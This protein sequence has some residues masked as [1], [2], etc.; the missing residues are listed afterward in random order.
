MG[1]ADPREWPWPWWLADLF[2][3]DVTTLF[4][5]YVKSALFRGV[6][7]VPDADKA[8]SGRD[9]A[10]VI[11]ILRVIYSADRIDEAFIDAGLARRDIVELGVA[12]RLP[13]LQV[14]VPLQ[15]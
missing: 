4:H 11:F 8:A 15:G 3:I 1:S 9:P 5:D 6:V 2:H 14:G 7:G 13:F 10:F 12:D